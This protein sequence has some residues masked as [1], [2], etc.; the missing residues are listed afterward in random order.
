M[1]EVVIG[2][3]VHRFS[4]ILCFLQPYF[5]KNKAHKVELSVFLKYLQGNHTDAGFV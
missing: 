3:I 1:N 4:S 5:E 2:I